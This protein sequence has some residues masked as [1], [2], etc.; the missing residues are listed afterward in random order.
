MI[1]GWQNPLDGRTYGLEDF[2]GM[3]S[4]VPEPVLRAMA[5][6][7]KH[8]TRHQGPN[9]TITSGLSCPRKTFIS[10][11]FPTYPDPTKMWKMQRGTWLHEMVGLS[12][13]EN[14][15]WVTEEGDHDGCVFKGNIFGTDMTCLIDARKK[16]WS[17]LI[18]WKFRG[19]GAERWIDPMGAAKTEDA[20]Q[21]NMARLLMEQQENQD[22]RDMAMY[23]WVMSGAMVKT[24]CA[25]MTEEQIGQVR[26]GG[27][28]Y[29]VKEIFTLLNA[30]FAEWVHIAKELNVEPTQVPHEKLQPV[31]AKM[32]MV[33]E[34][35][36][37][38]KRKGTNMCTSYCEVSDECFACNG[39]I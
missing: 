32:P 7:A 13:S 3:A 21:L 18:D 30:G 36:F 38:S 22:L 1:L 28:K 35:M 5:H 10:R 2:G 25:Y 26:P 39:G 12:L 23:V 27:G 37:A 11:S 8:D 31:V 20:A 19:D 24:T 6:K 9:V 16:D 17:Q 15:A 29:N 34:G 14:D 4:V 33:G